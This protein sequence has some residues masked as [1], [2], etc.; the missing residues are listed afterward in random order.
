M[1]SSMHEKGVFVVLSLCLCFAVLG[2]CG[3]GETAPLV[4]TPAAG[5]VDSYFGGPFSVAGSSVGR[6]SSSFDHSANQI[7]V[8]AFVNSGQSLLVPTQVLSGSFTRADTGFLAVTENFLTTNG[9]IITPQNPPLSGAWAVEIPG[10][11]AL[12]NLLSVNAT[13]TPPIISAAPAVM[14]DNTTCPD[15]RG[16]TS[17]LYV[18][19]PNPAT[20][21][22]VD[23]SNYGSVGIVTQGSDVTFTAKPYLIGQLP[24][25]ASVAT[26]GC[27]VSTLGALTAYPLNS[28]GQTSSNLELISIGKSGLLV[29][30]F[31]STGSV[32]T[33]GA[34]GGGYG[35]IGVQEPSSPV[36]VNAVIGGKYNGFIYAPKN[37]V[38][39]PYDI[40][41]LASAF[42]NHAGND[43]A[44]SAL[45]SS[46]AANHGQG[47]G[48]VAALPSPNTIYGGEF[49]IV[50]SSGS[51]NDPSGALGSENCDVAIDLGTQDSTNSG[52]FPNATIFIGAN[53]PP[54]SA[55][56]LWD[57][58][59][60]TSVCA[61]SFPSAAVVGQVQGQY[62]MFVVASAN[63][64]PPAQLPNGFGSPIPQPVGI[65]L[66]QK[67][68]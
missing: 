13:S 4:S 59:G 19:V 14:A 36:D 32:S 48:T 54:Y 31:N 7:G 47:A 18:N 12:A 2:L 15:F 25:T 34:F 5:K 51:V 41:V 52:L 16:P 56:N 6:S 9:G 10:A 62:V 24:G 63:S 42:G 60:T 37:A 49:L 66:F 29:S 50:G 38:K 1:T 39:G 43:P 65:Y 27:S 67:S 33:V 46:L 40:T 57:C 17:F 53:Y 8:S 20:L 55:S 45:Q 3:C 23:T 22:S 28:Y 35:V 26:G 61:V 21:S 68:Q 58:F 64:T 11:G 44:C 30:S